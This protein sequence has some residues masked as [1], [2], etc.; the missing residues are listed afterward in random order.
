MP[1][2]ITNE[3]RDSSYTISRERDLI[4]ETNN[5][6]FFRLN[7]R[8]LEIYISLVVVSRGDSCACEYLPCIT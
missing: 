1:M 5:N 4:V 3:K 6:E 7:L 2:N 8:F